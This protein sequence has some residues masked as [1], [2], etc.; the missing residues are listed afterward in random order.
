MIKRC[1]DLALALGSLVVLAPLM[2]GLAIWVRLDSRGPAIYRGRR[3]GR[4]GVP[5][6]M[7]KFRTMVADAD[8]RGPA[9]TLGDDRRITRAGTALR[10][11]HLD[12]LPQLLNVLRGEMSF[13]GPRPETPS[14]VD[15]SDPTWRK[16]LSV[17]PGI[18][19]LAQLTFADAERTVLRRAETLSD[20]YTRRILPAKL[21]ADLRY[22]ERRSLPL[23]I[24]LLLQ[25]A[26]MI[27]LPPPDVR[28]P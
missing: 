14:F 11:T 18:C 19:G 2:L 10:R 28:A 9:L 16:V 26:M 4:D 25:T 24:A 7:Y 6:A 13:V 3:I 12:E 5:F 27:A 21:A 23:D 15:L 1:F 8:A 20:D 17:R 22:I